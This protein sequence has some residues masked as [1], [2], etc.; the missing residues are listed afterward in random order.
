MHAIRKFAAASIIVSGVGV[1][2]VVS[3]QQ[4]VV[5]RDTV[6]TVHQDTVVHTKQDTSVVTT[7]VS[8]SNN[9][10]P[11][12]D[13][14]VGATLSRLPNYKTLTALLMQAHLMPSLRGAAPMTLFAPTDDAFAKL[15]PSDMDALKADTARLRDLLLNMMVSGKID[16]REI[17]KLKTATSMKGSRIRFGYEN[18]MP[19]VNDQPI[20]Q[21]GIMAS[22]GFIYGISGVIG[23]SGEK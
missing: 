9:P 5:K 23:M 21:P 22:N 20:V 19:K 8:S 3:A 18:G 11:A 6:I 12:S 7:T 14:S 16:T 17:L 2:A 1:P 13:V 15:T 10:L 4:T